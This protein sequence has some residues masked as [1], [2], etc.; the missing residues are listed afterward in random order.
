MYDAFINT[1]NKR[2]YRFCVPF[3]RYN[4][5]LYYINAHHLYNLKLIFSNLIRTGDFAF[6]KNKLTFG[7]KLKYFILGKVLRINYYCNK[8]A[9]YPDFKFIKKIMK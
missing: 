3:G 7:R 9:Q 4:K 2:K 8:I 6:S 1:T 5:I